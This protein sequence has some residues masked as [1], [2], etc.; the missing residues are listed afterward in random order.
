MT[1]KTCVYTE[2]C[3]GGW[4]AACCSL[5]ISFDGTPNDCLYYYCQNCGGRVIEIESMAGK[6]TR[7]DWRKKQS[8]GTKK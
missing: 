4:A 1:D 8:T 5:S 2:D 7:D 6:K 3:G